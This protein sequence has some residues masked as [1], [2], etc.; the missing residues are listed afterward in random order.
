MSRT[1]YVLSS[2]SRPLLCLNVSVLLLLSAAEV[3]VSR[4]W[5]VVNVGESFACS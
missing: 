4:G 3:L 5:Y 1:R 2:L